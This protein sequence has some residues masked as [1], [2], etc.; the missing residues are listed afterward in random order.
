MFESIGGSLEQYYFAV[1]HSTAY[2][3]ELFPDE[4]S[5]HALSAAVLAGNA[6]TPLK[7]TAILSSSE[8]IEAFQKAADVTYTPPS[9]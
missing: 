4:V 2:V 1:G 3:I 5:A 7:T 9:S 8:A 6:V